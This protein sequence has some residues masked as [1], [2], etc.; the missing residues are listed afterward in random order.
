MTPLVNGPL[1]ENHVV[2]P[3]I[4][5]SLVLAGLLLLAL[6]ARLYH[7]QVVQHDRY[8]TLAQNNRIELLPVPPV[9]GLIYDRN[10]ELLARNFRVYNLEILP[11]KV[12][13][14]DRLLN[15]LGQLVVL[16]EDDIARFRKLLG[17]R[18]GFESQTLR[19]NL[20]EVEAARFAVNQHRLPGAYLRARLQRRYPHG[21]LTAEVVGYVGRISESDLERI[22]QSAYRGIDFIGKLGIEARYE[23]ELLGVAGVEKVETNAHGRLVRRLERT[24][25]V[26][27]KSLHLTIDVGLQQRAREALAGWDGSVVAIDPSNGDILAF[28]SEPSFDPNPFVEG[29]G[30]KAYRA[31]RESPHKP[32]LNRALHGRYPPG[33]TIKG[34]LGLVA[35]DN[36]LNPGSR[37]YCPGWYSLPNTRHRYRCWKKTGHGSVD[38]RKAITESCDVYFY[39]TARNLGIERM[40]DGL[41]RFGFGSKTGVD[42]LGEPSA[43]MPS[44]EWK[45]RVHGQPWYPGETVITG[46]GQGYMLATP[47]QLAAATAT[48]A[49]RGR[50]VRPRFLAAIE[51]PESRTIEKLPPVSEGRVSI[52]SPRAYDLVIE[53]MHDVVQGARGTAR[54]SGLGAP[55]PFAGKTGTAQVKGI[56]QGAKYDEKSVEKKF[57]DHALFIAFAPLENPRIALAVIAENGG[58]GS[59]TAAPI[60][61]KLLDYWLIDRLGLYPREGQGDDG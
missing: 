28:V 29:I 41:Q 39:Q 20:S 38:L 5:F 3:R 26:T 48:L 14:M 24:P 21:A 31:L 49:N 30:R 43:L 25:P 55:Y 1:Y 2:Q 59:R 32:L 36:S 11:D 19:T 52:S 60:A 15:D 37:I 27:G 56:A 18:P 16:G 10:G 12:Q 34:F 4:V 54:R 17:R 51:D 53:A 35:L 13:D 46:I 50:K 33:S 42:L 47:L 57:R 7:L 23:R 58:S 6:I 22:D 8:V 61:R 9:R 45:E 40:H 44:R